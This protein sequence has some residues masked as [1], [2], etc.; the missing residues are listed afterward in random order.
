MISLEEPFAEVVGQ[1]FAS[2]N[3][4]SPANLPA[5]SQGSKDRSEIKGNGACRRSLYGCHLSRK[6]M[7]S[8]NCVHVFLA[9]LLMR[10]SRA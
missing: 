9:T 4:P 7:I 2:G 5:L 10:H 8:L 1:S 6:G 3:M